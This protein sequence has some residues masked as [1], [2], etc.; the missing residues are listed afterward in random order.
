MAIMPPTR[1]YRSPIDSAV[2][3]KIE[4]DLLDLFVVM[5]ERKFTIIL[6]SVIGFFIGMAIV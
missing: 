6:A 1:E 5:A 3:G 2:K 4:F